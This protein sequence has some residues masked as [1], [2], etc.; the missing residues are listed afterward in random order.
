MSLSHPCVLEVP[1]DMPLWTHCWTAAAPARYAHLSVTAHRDDQMDADDESLTIDEAAARLGLSVATVRRRCASGE[2]AARKVGRNWIVDGRALPRPSR[3][4]PPRRTGTAAT[5]VDLPLTLAHLRGQDLRNDVWVPD[6]LLHE[7]DLLDPTDLCIEAADRIDGNTLHE[8]PTVVPVPK[9]PFF[10]RNAV[11]LSLVDRVAYHAVVLAFAPS[12]EAEMTDAVYSARLSGRRSCL[13]KNGRDGWLAW[14]RA[15]LDEL[16]SDSPY[17]VATDIT[18]Y[19]DFVKHEILLPELLDVGVDPRLIDALRRMLKEWAPAPNTGIPQGPDASRVLGNFYMAAVDH[20]MADLEGIR[21]FRFMDDIRIL[22]P[23]RAVVI[24]ALQRL[25]Q[26]CR[27]RGLALSTKK[28][29]LLHGSAAVDSMTEGELDAAQYAFDSSETD[30]AEVRKQL[31][32]LFRKAMQPDGSVKTRWARFSLSR[33][34]QLRDKS[35]LNRVLGS[36][37]QLAPLGGL[38]PR[39]LH[40]WL[41]RPQTR[42]RLNEFLF[43]SERNTSVY[44]STW[45]LA[46]MLDVPDDVDPRWVDYARRVALDRSEPTFHRTIALNVLALGRQI[47]DLDSIRQVVRTEHDPEI[48]RAGLVALR[49][50]GKLTRDVVSQ[51]ARIPSLRSTSDYLTGRS[52]LPSLVFRARR[53]Q[54]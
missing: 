27:R 41:R 23:S 42:Q 35:V 33:L 25:D 31:A 15:V 14:R 49:R 40:P 38:V 6:V 39:Y 50:V 3:R 28:T 37:E 32:D 17:M 46:V 47:R 21:Y 8:P 12:V 26:E 45:L 34:F 53:V 2:I 44:L 10:P 11:N 36:L 54:V 29:E 19:F 5:L 52:D 1:A 51:S 20:V 43:D 7:D 4:T 22:G 9:S 48:V 24:T 30:D 16:G 13:L 18:S